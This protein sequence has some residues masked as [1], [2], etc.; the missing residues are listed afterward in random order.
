[1]NYSDLDVMILTYN[2]SDFLKIALKAICESTATWNRTVVLNNASTDNTLD[3]VKEVQREY[4]KRKIEIITNEVNLGNVGNFKRS[5]E[6]ASNKYVAIFHDDDAVHPE[7]IDRAMKLMHEHKK[8]V[9][10]S[11]GGAWTIQRR[12]C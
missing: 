9:M 6:I 11:G 8:V 7:Y 2:R 1:M 4:P 5:Q 10:S 3:I 12:Q